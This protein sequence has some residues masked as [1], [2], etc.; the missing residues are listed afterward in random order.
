MRKGAA[1]EFTLTRTGSTSEAFTTSVRVED[2]GD[3]M[4]GNHWDE[5]PQA[6]DYEQEV[7][8]PADS[9]TA[10]ASFPTRENFRDTGDLSLTAFL[11]RTTNQASGLDHLSVQIWP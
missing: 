10:T 3:A 4:R 6:S 11:E 9:A 5:A 7:T 1:A 8:F 2:P